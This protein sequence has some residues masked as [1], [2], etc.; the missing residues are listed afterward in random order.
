MTEFELIELLDKVQRKKT[1][2]Q[3]LEIKSAEKGCPKRLYDTL[4]SFSNQDD[5]GVILF[6]VDE[7]NSFAEVGVYDPN[8]LQKHVVEQCNQMEPAI[9]PIFTV[10]NR[11]SLTFVSAEIP[12]IDVTLRPCFY[13]GK[14]RTKG[15]YVRVGDADE[16][17]TEYE[18]YSYEA[19]RKKHQDDKR[20]CERA[21]Y[22]S[23]E[24]VWLEEYLYK[25]KSGKPNLAQLDESRICELMSVTKDGVPTLSALM[26]FGT[27][28]QA[29]YPQLCIT[30]IAIQ[31]TE[32]GDVGDSGERF[33]DNQRIE[34]TLSQMLD[35]ALSFVRKNIKSKT[36]I[37]KN[38]GKRI[39][40]LEYPMVAVREAILN[41][42]I[43]RDYSIHTESMSIQ[44]II[45]ED[46]LEIRNPG[47][48]Y[49]K[50]RVDQLGKIQP[51][52]RNPVIAVAMELLNKTE[53]RYSGISTIYREL[54][55]AGLPEPEFRNERGQFTVCFRKT[56]KLPSD[57]TDVDTSL[58]AVEKALIAFCSVPRTRQEIANFLGL[59][60][61]P[62]A[63]KTHVMPLV[64]KGVLH[65]QY[66]DSPRSR[67]Q[68]YFS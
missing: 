65:L 37:D 42:L 68:K 31:G 6:G 19:F 20:I 21:S 1:E 13:A 18:V 24:R 7:T 28:P 34:G 48:L 64:K 10:I 58:S 38:D 2:T 27:Y 47:G 11:D 3:T 45:F 57:V 41:A 36:I 29:Y 53:N 43:H 26:L 4:S 52:T 60:T 9:R 22:T 46:R 16:P 14:G 15:S 8:D 32:I 50:L 61:V 55:E 39:D 54:K 33:I 30:A 63:I 59:T 35:S 25:L 56:K 40:K 62:H 5:G 17:M 66:P 44:I 12:G 49:G 67:K 23:F 51:D